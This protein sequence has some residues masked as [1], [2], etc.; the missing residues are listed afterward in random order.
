MTKYYF[1]KYIFKNSL[2]HKVNPLAKLAAVS[3][4][5]SAS[6]FISNIEELLFLTALLTVGMIM[7]KITLK[8]LYGSVKTFRFLIIFTFVV[9]LFFTDKGVFIPVPQIDT[10]QNALLTTSKFTLIISYSALFTLSASPLEIAKA[11]YFFIKPFK[12]AGVNTKEAAISILVTIRFIPLLFDEADKIITAQKL[13]GL[14]PEK[15]GFINKLK[16]ITKAE[17]FIIPLFIRLTRWAE[18]I[19]QTLTYKNN[20]EKFMTLPCLTRTDIIFISGSIVATW[21]FYVI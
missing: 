2:L 8:E 17:S 19:S 18:Y 4:L 3:L 14:W 13:R 6:A 20:I 16:F 10:I 15:K 9:Q 11:L 21:V 1:G 12:K 7:A 5:M